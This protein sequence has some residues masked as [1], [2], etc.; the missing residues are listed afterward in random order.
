[1]NNSAKMQAILGRW[2]IENFIRRY[3]PDEY[4]PS[5]LVDIGLNVKK[6]EEILRKKLIVDSLIK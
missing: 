1:M 5:D 4:L 2:N 3:D 6:Q